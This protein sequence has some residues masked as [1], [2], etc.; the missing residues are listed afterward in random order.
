MEEQNIN[1]NLYK[2]L[3]AFILEIAEKTETTKFEDK[4]LDKISDLIEEYE[5]KRW[6]I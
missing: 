3:M 2:K 4:V 1:D 5:T 6:P